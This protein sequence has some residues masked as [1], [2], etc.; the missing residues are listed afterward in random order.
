VITCAG[1]QLPFI[2]T[3]GFD[4][5]PEPPGELRAETRTFSISGTPAPSAPARSTGLC[6]P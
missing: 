1:N 6:A 3:M 4:Q 5:Y 2:G